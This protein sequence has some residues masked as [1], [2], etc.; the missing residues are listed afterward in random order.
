MP[1]PEQDPREFTEAGIE[2]L[3]PNQAGVYGIYNNQ[4]WIYIG[5]ADDIRKRL[6]EH[7]NGTSD[8]AKCIWRNKPT[9]YLAVAEGS[10]GIDTQETALTQ[11]FNPICN[12]D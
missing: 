4:I 12:R 7:F 3:D 11:E 10:E 8:Q 1:F 2:I 5:K 9:H 6:L